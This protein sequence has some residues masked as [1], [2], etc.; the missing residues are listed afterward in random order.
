RGMLPRL[1]AIFLPA[2]LLTGGVVVALYYQDLSK[3]HTIFSQ[4]SAHLVDLQT[5]IID[6]ELNFVQSDLRY[7]ADQA[8]L[9]NFL[10]GSA[11]GRREMEAE[12]LLL[13]RQRGVYDQIRY[14]DGDGQERIRINYNEGHPV[15]VPE[16]DL[17]PKG[18]R[19]YFTQTRSLNQGEVF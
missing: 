17:Q 15:I 3:E 12:Y 4:S 18:N 11:A 1:L 5:E 14:L 9:R 8:V 13:S 6:R 7:L 19:Y 16:K 10:S 2:G